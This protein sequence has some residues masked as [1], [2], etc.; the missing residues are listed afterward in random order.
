MEICQKNTYNADFPF[1]R[2]L[3]LSSIIRFWEERAAHKDFSGKE[4][5]NKIFEKLKETPE[6]LNPIEDFSVFQKNQHLLDMIMSAVFPFA[7]QDDELGCAMAPY[8]LNPFYTTKKF[9]K[10]FDLSALQSNFI[11][12]DSGT[13]L[14]LN[15]TLKAYTEILNQVYG[16]Q[17][18]MD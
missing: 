1:K 17:V 7:M 13:N 16:V 6:F 18:F 11:L 2:T 4:F 15:K 14:E 10:L 12:S 9:T 8:N 3:T 5:A